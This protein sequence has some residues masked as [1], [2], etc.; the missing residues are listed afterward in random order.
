M[1]DKHTPGKVHT[2]ADFGY[3]RMIYADTGHP[4]GPYQVAEAGWRA[5]VIS[6]EEAA[7]NAR[8]FRACWNACDGMRIAHI[9]QLAEI[10]QGVMHLTV[11]ADDLKRE[12]DAALAQRDELLAAVVELAEVTRLL[13]PTCLADRRSKENRIERACAVVA[14]VQGI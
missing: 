3:P 8:R 6:R 12:R 14:K 2:G 13:E 9:E 5:G 4:E 11:Y 7:A 10:G 1:S